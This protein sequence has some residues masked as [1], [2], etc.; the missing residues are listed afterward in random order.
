MMRQLLKLVVLTC[1]FAMAQ[2]PMPVHAEGFFSPWVGVNFAH[3]PADGR[4]SLG[5]TGGNMGAGVFG[6]EIDFGYSP[7]FFGTE[8][9]F[10][11]NN[12]LTL[13]GNLIV[14]IPIGGTSGAGFRPFVTGGVGLLR[15]QFDNDTVFDVQGSRN[16]LGWNVGGGVMGYFN[17]HVGLRGD[18]RYTRGFEDLNTGDV[19]LDL[20]EGQ[21]RFWRTSIGVVIR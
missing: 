12:V 21:L 14:G 18:V 16:M 20:N 5:L 9:V 7:S 4:T 10:G 19:D 15:T 17:D 2:A 6:G 13:M 3:E 11:G 1:S 8:S